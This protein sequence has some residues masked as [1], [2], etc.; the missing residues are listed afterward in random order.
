MSEKMNFLMKAKGVK[1]SF[2]SIDALKEVNLEIGY[3]EIV[4]II[5]DNGAGKSTLIK[6]LTG[7]YS[8][9]NGELYWKGQKLNKLTVSLARELGIVTVFQD[10]ALSEQH[11]I[12]RNI[13]M[14]KELTN[15]WGFTNIRKEKE[16]TLKLMKGTMGFTSSAISPDNI[17]GTMSGGEQQGIAISRAL[18]FEASLR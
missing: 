9:D 11:S 5:G 18:Y 10:R 8:A 14:G 6:I 12:W 2:G 4:G 13:F 15:R 1:K 17:V 7:V 3:N 16:V